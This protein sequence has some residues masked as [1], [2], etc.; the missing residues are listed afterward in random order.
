MEAALDKLCLHCGTEFRPKPVEDAFCCVGCRFVNSLIQREGLDRYYDLKGKRIAGPVKSAVLQARDYEWLSLAAAEAEENAAADEAPHLDL[1]VQG[2][3]CVACVWLIESLFA[4]RHGS[5]RIETNVQGGQLRMSWERGEFEVLEFAGEL[6]SFGYLLGP[7]GEERVRPESR[8]LSMK[9]GICGAFALNSMAFS[10]PGYLGMTQDFAFAGV[11]KL[12]TVMTATLAIFVGGGYFFRRA[13]VGLK[14]GVLHIDAPISLGIITAYLGSLVGWLLDFE[15]LIYFDFVAIFIFLMLLGRWV[16]QLAVEKNR[17][18]LLRSSTVS[19]EKMATIKRGDLIDL[20]AGEMVP[21]RGSLME[22]CA[23]FS[24]ETING[25]AESRVWERGCEVPAGAVLVGRNP[26]QLEARESF[27]DSLLAR[28][29]ADVTGAGA[30]NM[31]LEKVLRVYLVVVTVLAL[32][33]GVFWLREGVASAL[34]VFISILVVSCPCA[35]GVSLPMVDEMATNFMRKA[36]LFVRRGDLWSRLLRVRR[37]VF[38]KTGTLTMETPELI[39][40]EVLQNVDKEILGALVRDSPHPLSR[41]LREHLFDVRAVEADVD[42]IAGA[43]VEWGAWSLGKPGWKSDATAEGME[44]HLC[45]EGML[46]ARFR[47][48]EAIR[49]DA[50][51]E[52]AALRKMGLEI[53]ILS[54]DRAGRV[55]EMAAALGLDA[56]D[57]LGDLSPDDKASKVGADALYVGDGAN[58]SLA[59]DAALCR[60]TPATGGSILEQKSDFYYLGRGLKA[61]RILMQAARQ[62][63][64][65]VAAVFGFAIVYNLVAISICLAGWMN[66][67]MA[68]VLMPTSSLITLG[69]AVGM[70]NRV[71]F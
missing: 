43:G 45:H 3:S 30:R 12:V 48:R 18:R 33:G 34:Q 57:C 5:L 11:F 23:E 63:R 38:D 66:P 2:I 14:C 51:T 70:R 25:E 26:V 13:W 19:R 41:V 52:L 68:A 56:K 69:I 32:A 42:D 44:T 50:E 39:N 8:E 64:R 36:G 55:S 22:D 58:D 53:G 21:V 10:L 1:D 62:R 67:L 7:I 4:R 31:G 16:Q 49:E 28:L 20:K 24:L 46:A 27:E 60:G 37:V 6:Q 71:L 54:G 40:P 15:E 9:L 65:A 29:M 35:L 59:F 17:N 61:L 47:F